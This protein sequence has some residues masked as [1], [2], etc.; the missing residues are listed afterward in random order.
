MLGETSRSREVAVNAVYP[1]S[2][3]YVEDTRA[4]DKPS[5]ASRSLCSEYV[6]LDEGSLVDLAC[7]GC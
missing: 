3:E 2:M 6:D 5:V 4:G 1:K 7:T